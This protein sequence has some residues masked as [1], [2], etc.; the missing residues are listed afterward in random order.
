M[1][2]LVK[3]KIKEG[4]DQSDEDESDGTIKRKELEAHKIAM[5]KE[6]DT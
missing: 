4:M 3:E 5:K 6:D 1:V 2:D